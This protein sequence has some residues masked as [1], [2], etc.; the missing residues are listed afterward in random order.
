MR[1]FVPCVCSGPS[2]TA[3]TTSTWKTVNGASVI[4]YSMYDPAHSEWNSDDDF[5][6]FLLDRPMYSYLNS[7]G[8][9]NF[10]WIMTWLL[11]NSLVSAYWYKW[12][13]SCLVA[14]SGYQL[15]F[16]YIRHSTFSVPKSYSNGSAEATAAEHTCRHG[17]VLVSAY[18]CFCC[19]C[20]F[21]AIVLS[22]QRCL[23]TGIKHD[24]KDRHST[25][26]VFYRFIGLDSVKWT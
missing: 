26:S 23:R 14:F 24:W 6:H 15:F 20:N 13:M 12:W 18:C 3:A 7:S 25:V 9:A 16:W 8:R 2:A 5:Q 1:T 4:I 22:K 19:C 11:V 21:G 17:N 10:P